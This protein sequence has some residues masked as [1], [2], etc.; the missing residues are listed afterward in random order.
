MDNNDKSSDLT[1]HRSP[2]SSHPE[3]DIKTVETSP[4]RTLRWQRF[5]LPAIGGIV[6]VGGASWVLFNRLISPTMTAKPN[7]PTATPVQLTNP[8]IAKI[9]DRSDYAASLESRQSVRVQPRVA[10]QISKIFVQPGDRVKA[11]QPLLQIDA[12][13]QRAQV[14]NR[15]ATAAT[16][17][18][19]IDTAQ[20]NVANA[21]QTLR[22]LVAE[23]ASAQADVQFKQQQYQRFEQLATAG[24]SSQQNVAQKLNDLRAAS[25]TLRTAEASIQAQKSSINAARS[26]VNRSRLA[27]KAAQANTAEGSAQLQ[28]YTISAPLPGIVG[29]ISRQNRRCRYQ[30]DSTLNSNAKRSAGSS[31]SDS[32]RTIVFITYWLTSET[33]RQSR[34]RVTNR[35]DFFYRTR[36]RSSNAIDSSESHLLKYPKLT[37]GSVYS[38]QSNL[39][40]KFWRTLTHIS[41]FTVGGAKFCIC[42]GSS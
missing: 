42:S 8:K 39:A 20:A 29:N 40:G 25:A 5:L 28:Y 13:Q 31:T 22:S 6:I 26:N 15:Q 27:L 33:T 3:L 16:A 37:D 10:G 35:T 1:I 17:A 23:R 38:C 41:N 12:A 18:A 21:E 32:L 11:G 19:E 7:Q 24:A 2:A 36:C 34:S 14:A 30:Y 9:Q 4:G